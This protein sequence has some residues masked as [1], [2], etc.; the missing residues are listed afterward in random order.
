[1]GVTSGCRLAT[2]ER[3]AALSSDGWVAEPCP[4]AAV[5]PRRPSSSRRV[6]ARRPTVLQELLLIL[7]GYTLYSF[8]RN[9]VPTREAAAF[10]NAHAVLS[11]ERALHI[12]IELAVN[13][14]VSAVHWLV[15]GANYYYASL[16]FAVTMIV[17]GW[18][19]LRHPTRYR[20]A[21]T[22]LFATNLV[23]LLG[24]WLY[25]L[26][27]PRMLD[28]DGFL[29]TV[30]AFHTW[31]SWGTSGMDSASNQFAAMPSLHIGWSLWCA[32]VVATVARRSWVKVLGVLYPVLTFLVI[33][34]TAN[35]FVLDAAGGVIALG[36]GFLV[37]RLL[38]VRPPLL[39]RPPLRVRPPVE[40]PR[41]RADV[42][43]RDAGASAVRGAA[44]LDPP[45]PALAPRSARRT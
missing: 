43:R 19:W 44:D 39:V 28:S 33:V 31:G 29:D 14:A 40:L 15:V 9:G 23:A 27:P 17:L 34:A 7:V 6:T 12:N 16:H 11:L 1:M 18:L 8:I 2:R 37:Q 41:P 36:C 32:L 5:R 21:R 13:Q 20:G 22:V 26:A 42:S 38:I 35:H 3:S 30:V 10:G 4:T 24:F 45:A 25:P